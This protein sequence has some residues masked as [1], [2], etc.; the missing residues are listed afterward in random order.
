MFLLN[1]IYVQIGIRLAVFGTMV[2][3][4]VMVERSF[5]KAGTRGGSLR[6]MQMVAAFLMGVVMRGLVSLISAP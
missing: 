4:I 5:R 1:N 3:F 6:M 2:I